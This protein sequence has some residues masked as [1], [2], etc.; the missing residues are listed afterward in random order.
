MNIKRISHN[1]ERGVFCPDDSEAY[2][3]LYF[4]NGGHPGNVLPSSPMLVVSVANLSPEAA[5]EDF[6]RAVPRGWSVFHRLLGQWLDKEI[7][8]IALLWAPEREST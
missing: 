3:V 2:A 7:P 5:K 6:L 4:L 1:G 8:R